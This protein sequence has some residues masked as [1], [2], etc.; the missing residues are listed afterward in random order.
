[1]I[2]PV[3]N[4]SFYVGSKFYRLT[5]IKVYRSETEMSGFEL[6]YEVPGD[7]TGYEPISHLFGTRQLVTRFNVKYVW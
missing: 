7:F 2:N 1:M 3:T 6:I 4:D 5:K